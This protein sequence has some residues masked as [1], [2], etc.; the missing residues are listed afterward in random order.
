VGGFISFR[1]LLTIV[2]ET[3]ISLA[4]LNPLATQKPTLKRMNTDRGLFLAQIQTVAAKID[5]E[6]E[7]LKRKEEGYTE[8]IAS[9]D[10]VSY[11]LR[12]GEYQR[13]TGRI[14][15]TE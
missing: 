1:R 5:P 12:R 3:L 13:L 2:N 15:D 7:N 8:V 6:N 14:Y 11:P 10:L 4:T 9:R